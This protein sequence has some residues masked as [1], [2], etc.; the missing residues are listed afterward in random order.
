M[1]RGRKLTTEQIQQ[2]AADRRNGMTWKAL[3]IKYKVA[4]NTIRY[5][6]AE[7]SDEFAPTVTML[8]PQLENQLNTARSEK[9]AGTQ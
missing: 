1:P 8:R 4:V 9:K 5:S 6:L 3:S 7:Y 2:A